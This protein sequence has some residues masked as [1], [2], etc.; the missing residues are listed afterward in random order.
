[1]I[2]Y[3]DMYFDLLVLKHDKINKNAFLFDAEKFY[4]FVISKNQRNC[5]LFWDKCQELI[6]LKELPSTFLL[7]YDKMWRYF[8][9]YILRRYG[10]VFLPA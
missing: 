2:I 3:K 7:S 6:I 9:S 1:M 5:P 8:S 4:A 10:G